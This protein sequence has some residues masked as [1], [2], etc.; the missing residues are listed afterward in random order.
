MSQC[1]ASEEISFSILMRPWAQLGAALRARNVRSN[2]LQE[3]TG[4]LE[5]VDR[6]WRKMEQQGIQP[7]VQLSAEPITILVI[8]SQCFACSWRNRSCC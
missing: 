3:L 6:F 1:F 2:P 4:D 7:Q 8:H 5:N